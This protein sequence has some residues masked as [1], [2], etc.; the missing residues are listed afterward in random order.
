MPC[1]S[2]AQ[3]ASVGRHPHSRS[4]LG[5]P[6]REAEVMGEGCFLTVVL[7]LELQAWTGRDCDGHLQPQHRGL[8]VGSRSGTLGTIPGSGEIQLTGC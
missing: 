5:A 3:T 2:S 7:T 4:V 1:S 8:W 6:A